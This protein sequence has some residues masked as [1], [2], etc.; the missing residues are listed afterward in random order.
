MS[1]G[2]GVGD[3]GSGKNVLSL[4]SFDHPTWRDS[5]DRSASAELVRHRGT[6]DR[7][8]SVLALC[9]MPHASRLTPCTFTEEAPDAPC[10]TDRSGSSGSLL[11]HHEGEFVSNL[12]VTENQGCWPSGLRPLPRRVRPARMF[13]RQRGTTNRGIGHQFGGMSHSMAAK[14]CARFSTILSE[15]ETLR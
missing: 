1:Q 10:F 11:R 13:F 5:F 12:L 3:Q 14:A 8:S 9:S 4:R 2:P 15:D 6:R 7:P